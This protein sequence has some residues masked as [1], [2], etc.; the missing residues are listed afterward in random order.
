MKKTH[1]CLFIADQAPIYL[2][3]M[4]AMMRSKNCDITIASWNEVMSKGLF[5]PKKFDLTIIFNAKTAPIR[6]AELTEQY[7]SES[8]KLITL[9]APV[10]AEETYAF[11]PLGGSNQVNRT[12]SQLLQA[13]D[14][15]FFCSNELISFED[16]NILKQFK[17]DTTNP[18]SKAY[19]GNV[20]LS[21]EGGSESGKKC[22]KWYSPDFYINEHFEIPITMP[23]QCD[24][25]T[26]SAKAK[27]TTRTIMLT[28]VQN[29]GLIFRTTFLPQQNWNRHLFFAKDFRFAGMLPG[30]P[31]PTNTPKLEFSKVCTIRFGHAVSHAYSSAGEQWFCIENVSAARIPFADHPNTVIPGL[32]PE[33]KYYPVTNAV[34]LES[35]KGQS[36]LDSR[37]KYILPK[38]LASISML[39]QSSGLD[40]DR[41]F[42]FIP[43]IEA[44][45]SKNLHCG[46]A[47]Y[48]LQF[49]N[50][51]NTD[52]EQYSF[53]K[54]FTRYN[55]SML[56]AF[57][58][59]DNSFY[60][61]NGCKAVCNTAFYMLRSIH[62][63]EAG[64]NEYAYFSDKPQGKAGAMIAVSKKHSSEDLKDICVTVSGCGIECSAQ[65]SDLPIVSYYAKGDFSL[66]RF[67]FNFTACDGKL[68]T[69]LTDKGKE[70]DRIECE[71][72]LYT[73]KAEKDRRFA[74]LAT[75]GSAEIEI[76]GKITRFYGVN[77]MPSGCIGNEDGQYHEFYFSK[78]AYDPEII[79]TDLERIA[80]IGM[81]AVSVFLYHRDCLNNQNLLHFIALCRRYGIYIDLGLRPHAT[82]FD[83]NQHEVLDLIQTQRLADCD[84]IVA[85]DISWERYNGTY[86]SCYGNHFGRKSY[87]PAFREYLLLQYGSFE[88]AQQQIGYPLP[89]N[90]EGEVIGVPDSMLRTDG[91]YRNLVAVYR[92]FVDAHVRRAHYQAANAIKQID[93]NHLLTARTG[94]ASTIP[95]VD[96]GIYG[97][98]YRCLCPGLDFFSPESYAL[99]ENP[100]IL[101]QILYT[102]EY[103]RFW[104]PNAVIQWKEFGK[105]IWCGSNFTDNTIGKEIQA[106]F[107]R[108]FFDMLLAGHTGG[109]YA[110]W[111]AGGYRIGENS[112]FGIINPDGSD[113]AVT[114]VMRDYAPKFLEAPAL[115]PIEG[116]VSIDRSKDSTAFEGNYRSVEEEF[117]SGWESGKRIS[118]TNAGCEQSTLTIDHNL[119]WYAD[120]M[121]DSF[122]ETII[123]DTNTVLI[124]VY[125]PSHCTWENNVTLQMLDE[126]RSCIAELPLTKPVALIGETTF[127]AD[128]S[129]YNQAT[130]LTL[131]S[132]HKP[133]GEII[134]KPFGEIIRKP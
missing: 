20:I 70:Y 88:N 115:K 63:L 92:K 13:L 10:F 116:K 53:A 93:P 106:N 25:L 27:D 110:W 28:L 89:R 100:N 90:E 83:Y 109:I 102:N 134:R 24:A 21:L 64:S 36:I 9:G 17:K 132:N 122:F 30:T 3:I 117:F 47:A 51:I 31:H 130:Y 22:L 65:L 121:P 35:A 97:Y 103:S 55:G 128:K 133:F 94:D 75:D 44:Y 5:S 41:R 15:G 34:K 72:M 48:M 60:C 12:Y 66:Y 18:D 101:R 95:L 29:D 71:V 85:Y 79:R 113:R 77:Y 33:Y 62:L 7:L 6:A 38:Q 118:F 91:E 99:S 67:E 96:P 105:S 43:L 45:D 104:Q 68:T 84:Q 123:E 126:N 56:A 87:D 111:W 69:I 54:D 14:H 78:T 59:N 82:P 4:Q 50:R 125:N 107:Y 127:I 16:E 73:E 26:L 19:D 52:T 11:A 49:H 129:D 98:D 76:D 74:K 23:Q 112:D 81:N 124:L 2:Q 119:P 108:K 131:A 120:G 37:E 86:E 40:K 61:Q 46:Y 39:S 80:D 1:N 58:P 32:Y 114:K 42:R 57:M 8:G